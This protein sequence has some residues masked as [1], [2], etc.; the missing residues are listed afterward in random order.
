MKYKLV[1]FDMDGV[2]YS[3]EKIVGLAYKG[4]VEKIRQDQGLDVEIPTVERIME[5]IGKPIIDIYRNLFPTLTAE[6]QKEIATNNLGELISLIS[7]KKGVLL[8]GAEAVLK[9][10]RSREV[11]MGL[12]SNGRGPYLNAIMD[13]YDIG[14]HFH[15]IRFIN[16]KELCSKADLINAYK[17]E[18]SVSPEETLMVGDRMSDYNAAKEAGVPFA[19]V[20]TGHGSDF[21]NQQFDYTVHHLEELLEIIS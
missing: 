18:F 11:Y 20:T 2:L 17:K 7:S 15:S 9:E 12:A 4:A 1:C 5:E 6:Q 16:G 14:Q 8:S 3:S 19:C 13:T 21:S 10:L